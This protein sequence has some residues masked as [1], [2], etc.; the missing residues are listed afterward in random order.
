MF[1]LFLNWSVGVPSHWLLCHFDMSLSFIE[2]FIVF[3]HK[4]LFQTCLGCFQLQP[5]NQT[6]LQW[7]LLFKQGMVFRN[8]DLGVRY[9]H[10]EWGFI[11]PRVSQSE[12][13]KIFQFKPILRCSV[14]QF[15]IPKSNFSFLRG[16][17][18]LIMQRT[19]GHTQNASMK[20]PTVLVSNGCCNKLA[21]TLWFKITQMHSLTVV[22]PRSLKSV[23]LG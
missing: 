9:V 11:I 21:E 13:E 3:S 5:Q 10:C 16:V 18:L 1:M 17:I 4:K 20:C 12:I 14:S 22:E 2:Y 8:Q 23:S 19:L 15:S 6:F 7:A